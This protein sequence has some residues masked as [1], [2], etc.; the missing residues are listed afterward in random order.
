MLFRDRPL[1]PAGVDRHLYVQ[2]PWLQDQLLAP[3]SQGRNVLLLGAAGAGKS[4]LLQ[5][6]AAQLRERGMRV[7]LV[8]AA[9]ARDAL[10]FLE[11]VA[12]ALGL[13]AN[14]D[15]HPQSEGSIGIALLERARALGDAEPACI[16]IDG[17]LDPDIGFEVFGR[18]RDELWALEH[19]WAVAV[20]PHDSGALRRPPADAFWGVVLEIPPL[21]DEEIDAILRAGLQGE[22]LSAAL[23]GRANKFMEGIW[24]TTPRSVVSIAQVLNGVGSIGS[25]PVGQ[26]AAYLGRLERWISTV[27]RSEAMALAEMRGT[28]APV[29]VHDEEFLG[30][31]GW[32]RP[33][34]QRVL[35][36]LEDQGILRS[37]PERS[38]RQGRPRKLY[39]LNPN[40]PEPS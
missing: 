5:Y 9:V 34:A 29:S 32:S 2:R 20:R 18:L 14:P 15:P 27:G 39:E 37:M 36:S 8:N 3:L 13:P 10:S 17:L 40:M 26:P 21:L 38:D 33:Y 16:L 30:R 28:R 31:L 11:L 4:T 25:Q 22:E 24:G 7:V 12:S 19:A 35:A 23:E 1:L 6:A